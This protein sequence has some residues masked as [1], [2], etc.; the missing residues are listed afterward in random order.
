MRLR[1]HK[2]R[3]LVFHA[4]FFCVC[5]LNSLSSW[6]LIYRKWLIAIL[7]T[8]R[9][10]VEL[11][12]QR[13]RAAE[14]NEQMTRNT[15]SHLMAQVELT[16][17]RL[18]Q[19]LEKRQMLMSEILWVL[20]KLLWTESIYWKN[21]FGLCKQTDTQSYNS[22]CICVANYVLKFNFRKKSLSMIW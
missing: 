2:Q 6:I 16:E 7:F 9:C 20:C 3:K 18:G 12:K 8:H 15:R 11:C 14:E 1:G 21:I 10:T 5:P 13:Q 19:A 17:S 22:F 4:Y